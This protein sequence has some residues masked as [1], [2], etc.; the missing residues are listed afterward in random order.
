MNEILTIGILLLTG[1]VLGLLLSKIGIP[2]I[3]GYIGT[4]IIFSPFTTNF[5][6]TNI[7][8]DTQSLM[9]ICLAF[10]AFEV[11][12]ALKWTKIK[13][14]ENEII[15]ITLLASIIPLVLITGGVLVLGL[16]FPS[17]VPFE[18]STLFLF[19]LLLGTLASP[20][21]PAATLAVIHEYKAKGK[22]TETILGVAALDDILGILLFSVVIGLISTFLEGYNGLFGANILNTLYEIIIAIILGAILALFLN[23]LV[24]LLKISGEGQW[25]VIIFSFIVLCVGL[26]KLMN[27]NILLTSMSMGVVVVN[28]SK[29]Q[30]EIFRILER[31]TEDLIFLFF[32]VLSGLH[33]DIS[34]IP[35]AITIIIIFVLL[36]TAGKYLGANLGARMAKADTSIQ[37]Y[38]AGGL[39]PQAG[40]VIGLVLSIYPNVQF[41]QISELLLTVIMGA[42]IIHE[43]IGPLAAKASLRNSGEIKGNT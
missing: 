20:T 29:R 28:K 19:S 25:I 37:K 30:K 38:T 2:K 9:D 26:T 13:K 22:V 34:T 17:I 5:L 3:I 39:I 24:S 36:R 43:I 23:W 10:I 33:L 11:G 7:G 35:R 18:Y 41:G 4:G 31:Y 6:D 15:Y 42:T 16:L 12:G 8:Q 40:I 1:Y 21:A 27:I 14:H 32:F